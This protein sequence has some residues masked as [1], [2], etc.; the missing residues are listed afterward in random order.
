MFIRT[1]CGV[2]ITVTEECIHLLINDSQ[3][4]VLLHERSSAGSP[5][6]WSVRLLT[7]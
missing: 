6:H 1:I 7:E 5:A 2:I 4:S 3:V